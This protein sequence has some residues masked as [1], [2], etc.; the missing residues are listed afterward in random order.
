ML[1]MLEDN[2]ERVRR[3]TE[4]LRAIDPGLP[5]MIWR[6]AKVMVREVGPY[7]PSAR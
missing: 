2:D 3:F 5:L 1:L 4:V 6:D 7:L